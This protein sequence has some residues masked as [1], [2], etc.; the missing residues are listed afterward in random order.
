M[1]R[2]TRPTDPAAVMAA[3]LRRLEQAAA[4]DRAEAADP[5][6]WGVAAEALALPAQAD[7]AAVRDGRGRIAQA[8]RT[9]VFERLHERGS[10]TAG[11][12]SAVRRLEHD[13][14]SRA[15]LFRPPSDLVK[16]D[17][18]ARVSGATE[19]MLEAGRRVDQALAACGPRSALLLRALVEPAVL[20][21]EAVAWR[22][23]VARETAEDNPHAQAAV[24]RAACDN[25]MLAYQA[26]D[27][28]R[29]G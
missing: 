9:D 10:L 18:Q 25:L 8:H 13:I 11:Q 3:R 23:V 20:K 15:G 4:L 16:V 2:Q 12:L 6:R 26:L 5:G 28:G 24:V 29:R 7:V 1:G 21:G 22:E 14:G 17:A 27:R 19:R